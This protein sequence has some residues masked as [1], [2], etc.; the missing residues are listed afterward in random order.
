MGLRILAADD[1]EFAGLQYKKIFEKHQ[2]DIT[3][4]KD[5]EACVEIYKKKL[6]ENRSDADPFNVILLDFVMPKKNG[7]RVAKEILELRPHQKIIFVSAFG[8]GILDDA[9]IFLKDDVEII[10]KPFSLE[11]LVNKIESSHALRNMR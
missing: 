8:N 6:D 9:S 2:H 5:G 10:Q 4:A 11:F 3:I 1:N 7:V